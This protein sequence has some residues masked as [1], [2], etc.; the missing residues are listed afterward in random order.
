ML[1]LLGTLFGGLF[2]L[3]PEAIK[4]VDKKN[5]RAHEISMFDLQL[6][7]DTLKGA[8]AQRLEE[9]KGENAATI[10]E[11]QAMVEAVKAQG[12]ATGVKWVDAISAT[13]RPFLTYWWAVILYT[14]S[15]AAEFYGLVVVSQQPMWSSMAQIFGP[16]EKAIA[17]SMI[18]FWFV[19]RAIRKMTGK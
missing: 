4:F 2:R 17:A 18:S 9:I 5:E 8:Q 13:V 16:D 11:L 1:T 7:A 10:G 19:D 14:A 12:V 3:A 15:M 6:K